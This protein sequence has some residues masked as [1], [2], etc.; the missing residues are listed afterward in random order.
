MARIFADPSAAPC[1]CGRR[2]AGALAC[3][4]GAPPADGTGAHGEAA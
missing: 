3:T 4:G 2:H 1:A